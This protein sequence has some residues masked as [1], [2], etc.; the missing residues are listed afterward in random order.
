[1]ISF[2]TSSTKAAELRPAT[3]LPFGKP[4][5][6]GQPLSPSY[7]PSFSPTVDRRS[8]CVFNDIGMALDVNRVRRP[9]PTA[10]LLQRKSAAAQV[11][12]PPMASKSTRSPRL[13]RRS[14]TASQRAQRDRCRRRVA[15]AINCRRDFRRI[16]AELVGGAVDDALVSLMR[17][18]PVHIVGCVSR[19]AECI[20]DGVRDHRN[21]VAKYPSRPSM[22]TCP[23]VCVADGPPSTWKLGFRCR[24][25]RA[26]K[27][28]SSAT[29]GHRRARR[30][31]CASSTTA[32]APSPNST[33]VGSAVIPVENARE[34]LTRRSARALVGARA[35]HRIDRRQ[36]EHETRTN[37]LQ[38]ECH[39]CRGYRVQPAPRQRKRKV[40]SGVA[41]AHQPRSD[42]C[43]WLRRSGMREAPILQHAKQDRVSSAVGGDAPL[44][45]A[46]ALRLIHS[47]DVSTVFA[48]SSLVTTRC[49]KIA[50][51]TE[52]DRTQSHDA[53]PPTRGAGCSATCERFS[54]SFI[55]REQLA[56]RHVVSYIDGGRE[57][58]VVRSAM[59]LDDD[60]IETQQHATVDFAR[61]HL[62][63][64]RSKRADARTGSQS[65]H[66][67]SAAWHYADMTPSDA[68][69]LRRP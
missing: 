61:I 65:G 14:A 34:S 23:T 44:V 5:R 54:I 24:P 16:D 56:A 1:M 31:S 27:A 8:Y 15:V 66:A 21:G 67:S 25:S 43:R 18:K 51:N 63:A 33:Q 4:L 36:S 9:E 48:S 17:H 19:C 37:R 22:R 60:A 46:G 29:H 59:A 26:R 47:S 58:L 55:F 41:V 13:I 53:T 57:P 7:R 11:N 30:S 52:N 45:N 35:Q 6:S 28:V 50:A 3:G 10:A 64:Q 62:F 42:R 38:V 68:P 12:P 32:P 49:G 40:L 2:R 39:P 69:F 20:F